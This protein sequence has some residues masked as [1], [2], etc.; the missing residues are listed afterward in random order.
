MPS[1]VED[2]GTDARLSRRTPKRPGPTSLKMRPRLR[3]GSPLPRYR[4]SATATYNADHTT[5]NMVDCTQIRLIRSVRALFAPIHRRPIVCREV[6]S[7]QGKNVHLIPHHSPRTCEIPPECA[8]LLVQSAASLQ[9]FAPGS[10]AAHYQ[11]P[12]SSSSPS[13][14]TSMTRPAANSSSPSKSGS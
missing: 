4:F 12:P 14:G 10:D 13:N 2:A 6:R 11:F 3:T 8:S 1:Y 5:P 7:Y 9:R